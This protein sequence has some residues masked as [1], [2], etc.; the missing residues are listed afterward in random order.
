MV[1]SS[2]GGILIGRAMTE[3]PDLFAVA[4]PDVGA[5]NITAGMND[6]RVIAWQPAK[7]AARLQ[8]YN[9]SDKPILFWTDFEAGHGIGETQLKTIERWADFFSFALWQTGHPGFQVK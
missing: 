6:P 9:A 2:A 3:R 1:G 8:E 7:F 4:V 5:L